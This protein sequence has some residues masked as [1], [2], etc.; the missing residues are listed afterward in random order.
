VDRPAEAARGQEREAT[1]VVEVGVCGDGRIER[2]RIDRGQDRVTGLGGAAPL[3]HPEVHED[4]GRRGLD[5][6]SRTGDF[7]GGAARRDP[8]RLSP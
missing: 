2:E 8:H 5:Q 6:V 4:P 1:G 3:E 7:P